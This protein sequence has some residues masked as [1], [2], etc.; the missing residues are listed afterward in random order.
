MMMREA[1]AAHERESE[2]ALSECVGCPEYEPCGKN[3][4]P[5]VLIAESEPAD[6][7]VMP[8]NKVNTIALHV[9]GRD[10]PAIR[11]EERERCPDCGATGAY[12]YYCEH[13][14]GEEGK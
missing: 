2:C 14:S 12:G 3:E 8:L 7:A 11:A 10:E 5:C 9:R 6:D 1:L 4:K 13:D